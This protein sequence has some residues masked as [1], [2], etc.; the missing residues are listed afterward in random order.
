MREISLQPPV[1]LMAAAAIGYLIAVLLYR[2]WVIIISSVVIVVASLIIFSSGGQ[3]LINQ[4][5]AQ[6]SVTSKAKCL[7]RGII[8]GAVFKTQNI[9]LNKT[10]NEIN[11]QKLTEAINGV[12]T[13]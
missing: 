8:E 12:Q 9:C 10:S 7:G 3:N 13:N 11:Y 4:V 5:N 2:Y 6:T 1:I